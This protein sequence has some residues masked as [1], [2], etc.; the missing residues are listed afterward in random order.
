MTLKLNKDNVL[1]IFLTNVVE[2][3]LLKIIS[4]PMAFRLLFRHCTKAMKYLKIFSQ[5]VAQG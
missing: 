4:V 3:Q 2:L 5:T 1:S